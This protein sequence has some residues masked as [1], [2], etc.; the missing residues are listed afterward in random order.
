MKYLLFILP[1]MLL[2]CTHK[3]NPPK[4]VYGFADC[5]DVVNGYYKG[6][7][8]CIIFQLGD[9]AANCNGQHVYYAKIEK[10]SI[11]ADDVVC[12]GDLSQF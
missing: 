7:I 1:L 12:H 10:N 11:K 4:E 6:S 5:L 8:A 9:D 2:N 3:N